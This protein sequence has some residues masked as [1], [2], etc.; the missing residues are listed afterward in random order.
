MKK[1]DEYFL[2]ELALKTEIQFISGKYF[3][4]DHKEIKNIDR[5]LS[6]TYYNITRK[7]IS[8]HDLKYLKLGIINNTNDEEREIWYRSNLIDEALQ[9]EETG[10][11]PTSLPFPLDDKQ[12]TILYVLLFHP[13]YEVFFI[14]TGVG[15]SGKSTFLN[16]VKQLFDDDVSST[17]L[18]NL[19]NQ[20][21]LA[22]AL[23][24][25]LIASDEI[26]AGE[27][28]LPIIKTIVSKQRIQVNEKFGA[29]YDT[30]AQSALFYCCN[31]APKIDIS[32]TGMLRRIVFYSRNTKI[33][34]PNPELQ[35]RRYTKEELID[36]ILYAKK[37]EGF[38]V[39]KPI[40]EWKKLFK[41]ETNVF[42]STSSSVGLFM[43]E[44]I[45]YGQPVRDYQ[46]YK[47]FCYRD[48]YKPFSKRKFDEMMKW[49]LENYT[50]ESK[51]KNSEKFEYP[52]FMVS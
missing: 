48:N 20:F 43:K 26:G 23:K 45:K 16:I 9:M 47:N 13:E 4:K 6:K 5:Y 31:E 30:L 7:F 28:D 19:S 15:G 1:Y 17:P 44:C 25:R 29:T 41:E 35:K 51:L 37:I 42:L 50:D 38:Y 2:S 22:E 40:D 46:G 12:L 27:V 36:F 3:S 21:M 8:E 33:E 18:S 39:G 52:W 32:D 24:H 14:T 11:S 49:L 10:Y 34:N